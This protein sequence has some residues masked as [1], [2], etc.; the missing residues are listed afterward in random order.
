M[1]HKESFTLYAEALASLLR[2]VCQDLQK[3]FRQT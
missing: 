2:E 1:K 3:G